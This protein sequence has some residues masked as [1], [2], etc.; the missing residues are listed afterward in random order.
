MQVRTVGSRR[1]F[2]AR[3]PQESTGHP[4]PRPHQRPPF[5]PS[6]VVRHG[7]NLG[8]H[9]LSHALDTRARTQATAK[10]TKSLS[11]KIAAGHRLSRAK[12]PRAPPH[13]GYTGCS[14]ASASESLAR[15]WYPPLVWHHRL[16]PY[17]TSPVGTSYT[18]P[19]TVAVAMF[20]HSRPPSSSEV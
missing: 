12:G 16:R 19:S 2:V 10:I 17:I 8:R 15:L 14:V 9:C 18:H 7:C 6:L 1:A 3:M 4:V 20:A 5:P 11:R 13:T